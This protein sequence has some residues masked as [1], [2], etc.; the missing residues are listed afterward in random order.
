[1]LHKEIF[2]QLFLE[3]SDLSLC[4]KCR[5]IVTVSEY[6]DVFD[7]M[8]VQT[9]VEHSKFSIVRSQYRSKHCA[10]S[11]VPHIARLSMAIPDGH[12][13]SL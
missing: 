11:F 12:D 8:F 1:M 7:R 6:T 2:G 13:G 10:A 9:R 3:L 4:C 5:K